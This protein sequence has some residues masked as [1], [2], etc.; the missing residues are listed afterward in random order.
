[1]GCVHRTPSIAVHVL[2]GYQRAPFRAVPVM[3][4]LER[5]IL[6]C[7]SSVVTAELLVLREDGTIR[8]SSDETY[9]VRRKFS[10]NRVGH[11]VR[12]GKCP[13]RVPRTLESSSGCMMKKKINFRARPWAGRNLSVGR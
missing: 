11:T 3:G 7:V 4:F 5:L 1:M 10:K 2:S 12:I 8:P 13:R 9:C 6:V